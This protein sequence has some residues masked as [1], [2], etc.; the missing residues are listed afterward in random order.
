MRG[1]VRWCAAGSPGDRE[2]GKDLV[3]VGLGDAGVVAGASKEPLA[4]G[5]VETAADYSA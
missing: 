3:E 1:R 4:G 2:S 5:D